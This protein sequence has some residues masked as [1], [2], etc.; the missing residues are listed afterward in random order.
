MFSKKHRIF[1]ILSP[2]PVR[3]DE[4]GKYS[5]GTNDLIPDSVLGK[6]IHSDSWSGAGF[7]KPMLYFA[8]GGEVEEHDP[9]AGQRMTNQQLR[10]VDF[11][12]YLRH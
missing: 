5:V 4:V 1:P 6:R 7:Q 12:N 2:F 3:S 8:K 11:S 10:N 9:F